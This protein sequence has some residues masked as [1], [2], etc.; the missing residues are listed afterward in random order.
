[1]VYMVKA[2]PAMALLSFGALGKPF[3][4]IMYAGS[5]AYERGVLQQFSMQCDIGFDAVYGHFRQCRAHPCH[6]LLAGVAK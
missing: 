4:E 5:A 2:R 1:M 6:C 3:F